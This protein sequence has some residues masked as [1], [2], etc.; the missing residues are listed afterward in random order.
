[1]AGREGADEQE[2][3]S[4]GVFPQQILLDRQE[5]REGIKDHLAGGRVEGSG[6]ERLVEEPVKGPAGLDGKTALGVGRGRGGDLGGDGG[7]FPARQRREIQSAPDAE[8][9][10]DPLGRPA[11]EVD[12]AEA[13]DD[14]GD[15]LA[16]FGRDDRHGDELVDRLARAGLAPEVARLGPVGRSRQG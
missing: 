4:E 8:T 15:D 2:G 3:R 14:G 7:L 9:A 11:V 16:G 10:F 12:R 1:M 5:R 13:E 6:V